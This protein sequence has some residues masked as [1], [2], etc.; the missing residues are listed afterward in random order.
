MQEKWTALLFK[1]CNNSAQLD[2]FWVCPQ[3]Y[4]GSIV[5]FLVKLEEYI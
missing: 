5:G 3:M 4:K 1:V 2:G